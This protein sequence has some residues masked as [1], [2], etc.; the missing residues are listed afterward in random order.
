[1]A[2]DIFRG[3]VSE[4]QKETITEMKGN[5]H[6]GTGKVRTITK[7][8][9]TFKIENKA[10]YIIC[11]YL[12]E[13]GDEVAVV[14][15]NQGNGYFKVSSCK[16]FTKLW[17]WCEIWNLWILSILTIGIAYL[18]GITLSLGIYRNE[19]PIFAILFTAVI[20]LLMFLL[21]FP[22][23]RKYREIRVME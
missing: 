9:Q 3:S 17:N 11:P 1:M 5:I 16:N 21:C 14:A 13:N 2:L 12:I 4:L 10:F 20:Y 22:I 7:T 8:K 19:N 23:R 18:L 15:T 6:K